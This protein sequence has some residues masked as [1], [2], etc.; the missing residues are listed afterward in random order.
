[1]DNY[2]IF[3]KFLHDFIF[4]TKTINLLL[5]EIEKLFYIKNT[6]IKKNSHIFIT[7]LPRSGT[8]SLLNFIYSSEKYASLTYKNMPF[9]LSPN[10]SKLFN[11]KKIDKKERM[12]GDGIFYDIDSP[13]AFDEV[14]F[15]NNNEFIKK[16][17]VNYLTLILSDK[18]KLMYLSKNNFNYK[19][20]DLIKSI[21]PNSIFLI[22]IREPLQHAYSLMCQHIHF[23]KLQKKNDF[24]KRY[25]NYLGHNEFGLNHKSWNKPIEFHNCNKIDYWLEQWYL[26]YKNI[27]NHYESYDNC[28]FIIYEELINIDYIKLLLNRVKLEKFEKMNLKFFTNSNKKSLDLSFSHSIYNKTLNLYDDYKNNFL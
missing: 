10:F 21:L 28:Y 22:P 7:S 27:K 26:F 3:Q 11:K 4:N 18:D 9:V 12:H 23:S 17:L 20:I 25:M 8:T 14:F 15:R 5:Y 19:R 6:E 2:N 1:M 13:E 16:E 24:I